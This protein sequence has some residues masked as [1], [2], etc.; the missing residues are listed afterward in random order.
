MNEGKLPIHYLGVPL[1]SKRLTAAGCDAL[2]SK[3]AGRIDSWLSRSLSFAGRLQL[4][5]SVLLSLQIYLAKVFI[6]PKRILFLLQ[7]KFNRFLWGGKDSKA[8]A[9]VS[10]DKICAPKRE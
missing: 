10:W 4:I 2:V 1:I 9:K 8:Q 7:Q 3:I 5:S 6:L